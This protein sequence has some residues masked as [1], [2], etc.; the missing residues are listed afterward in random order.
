MGFLSCVRGFCVL[1]KM[2]RRRKRTKAT[3]RKVAA[4]PPSGI[5]SEIG[6]TGTSFYRGF[7]DNDEYNPKLQGTTG[8]NNISKMLGDPQ[9]QASENIVHL[10]IRAATWEIDCDD[11]G[12]KAGLEEALFERISFPRFLEHVLQAWSFGFE[13]ME[14]VPESDDGKWWFRKLAHRGQATI[15]TWDVDSNGDL[16]SVSQQVWKDNKFRKI[17]IPAENLFHLAYDQIGNNFV[18]RSGLRAAYKPWFIK[19]TTERI[20]AMAVERFGLGTP[21]IHSPKEYDAADKTAAAALAKNYRAGAKSHL[22][23]PDGWSFGVAGQGDAGRYDPMPL[24]RYCDEGIATAVLAMVLVL[25][26]SFTGSYSLAKNLL[27]VFQLGLEGIADWIADAVNT[28]LIDLWLDWN[29]ANPDSVEA[30][31]RWSDLE[32]IQVDTLATALE[33]LQRGGFITPDEETERWARNWLKAPQKDASPVSQASQPPAIQAH[34]H[35]A[36]TLAKSSYWRDLNDNEKTMS[37]REIA[38][39]QDDAQE[40]CVEVFRRVRPVWVDELMDQIKAALADGDPSDIG[41]ISIPKAMVQSDRNDLVDIQRDVFRYGQTKVREEKKRQQK[42]SK[43]RDESPD[44]DE[45]AKAYRAAASL[46]LSTLASMMDNAA[47]EAAQD[48]YRTQR[49]DALTAT[50]KAAEGDFGEEGEGL[51]YVRDRLE[52]N[53]VVEVDASRLFEPTA[54]ARA[55]SMVSTAFNLGRDDIAQQ[56]KDDIKFARRSAILDGNVC[57]VCEQKDG[58]EYTV[59]TPEYYKQMPPDPTCLG[60]ASGSNQCRC[61]YEYIFRTAT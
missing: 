8:I 25:G 24:I 29:V 18:G 2:S 21:E 35:S 54:F 39:R 34:D 43:A 40:Q 19:E 15:K 51:A 42:T 36:Q 55:Q 20:A 49:E 56:V 60:N 5:T 31:I 58:S 33:R 41:D 53:P 23:L 46:Y 48:L 30:K 9:V 61:L 37:L 13:L 47:R 57:E 12:I 4:T 44:K 6:A 22:Y 7:L 1:D 11:V 17:P 52:G 38:G 32:M 59:G 10:P 50:I 28:Q 45:N 16:T 27:D 3:P 14:I 26:R